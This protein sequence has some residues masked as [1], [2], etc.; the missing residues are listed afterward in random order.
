MSSDDVSLNMSP[1]VSSLS[2]SDDELIESQSVSLSVVS[3]EEVC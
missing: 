3:V 2:S 1:S